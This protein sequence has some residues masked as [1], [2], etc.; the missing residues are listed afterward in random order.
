MNLKYLLRKFYYLEVLSF[1]LFSN[2]ILNAQAVKISNI[3]QSETGLSVSFFTYASEFITD[4]DGKLI[5]DYSAGMEEDSPGKPMLPSRIFFI[6]IPPEAEISFDISN[7]QEKVFQKIDIKVSPEISF[8]DDSTILYKETNVSAKYLENDIYPAKQIEI[9]GYTWVR[10]FYCAVIRI[11]PYQY[12]WKSKSISV[13]DSAEVNINFNNVKPFLQNTKPLGE[14]DNDLKDVIINFQEAQKFRSKNKSLSIQDSTASWIDYSKT[15]YKLGIIKDGIYRITFDNLISYGIS[16]SSVNPKTLKIFRKGDQIPLFVKGED[17]LSFDQDDYIEFWCEKNYGSQYYTNVV[18]TGQDYLNYMDRYSDTSMVWLTFGGDE[19]RRIEILNQA[20]SVTADTIKSHLSK[21]HF[22]QDIRLWYY[23]AEDPRTQLPFWQEHKVFTWLTIGNSGSQ[24]INFIAND[25]VPNTDVK[26]T[27]R[28]ISNAGNTTVNTHKHG[29]SLNSTTFQDSIIFNYRQTVNFTSTFSSNQLLNGSNAYR[30]FGLP[31]SATFH[32]SL[33]DWVDIEYYRENKT[34]NDSL[35]IVIPDTVNSDLRNIRFTNLQVDDSLIVLYKVSG[36]QKKITVYNYSNGELVFSDSVK[37]GD[38]YIIIK[39]DYIVSPIFKYSKDFVNLRDPSRGA[40]Y[41]IISHKSLTNSVQQYQQ[42]VSD[43][44]NVR[45]ELIYIDDIYDEFGFGQNW[46]ESIKGFLYFT[47]QNWTA[48]APSY[49]NLIGDANYDYKD[50]WNP[51]PSPRKKNLV[52]SYGNPV[53][54]NWYSIWDSTNLN[55]PQM[56]IGRIPANN[57]EEVSSYLEKY[58]IYLNRKFDDWNKRY[59]FYSGG[60]ATKP[61][62]LAQI[63]AANDSLYNTMIKPYPIGGKGIHFYKTITPPTN[64]GPYSP[65]EIRNAVDSSGLF[66]SYIGHSGTRTWDNGITEVEDIKNIFPD[67]YPLISDFGCSTGKFAEPDVDAFGELFVAQSSNGQAIAYLGNSSLGYLSTSLRYPG[68]FYKKILIDSVTTISKAHMLAK[69]EQFSLY[70]FSDVNRVF[71]FCNVLFNDPIIRFAVPEKPNF[72]IN[73]NSVLLTPNQVSDLEDSVLVILNIRNWGNVVQDSLN[74]EITNTFADSVIFTS[75]LKI[76]CPYYSEQIEIYVHTWGLVGEH[77]LSVVLD[78][79]NLI[80]EIYEN[81]NSIIYNFHVSSSSIRPVETENYYTTLQD[82]LVFLNPNLKTQGDPEEFLLSV[83]D[84]PEFNNAIEN[85]YSMGTLFTKLSLNNI[86]LGKRYWYRARLNVPQVDWSASYSFKNINEDF[87]WYIDM[88][89]NDNDLNKRNIEFDSTSQS[90]KI[91]RVINTLKITSAGSNDGKFASMIFNTQEYLPNTFFW[92]IA[93]SEIDSLTLEPS[94]IKYFSWPNSL[95]QNSDSLRNYILSLPQGKLLAMTISDDGVQLVLGSIGS[96]V[97]QAIKTL[98]SLYVDSVLYRQSWCLLGKKGAAI[99]SVPESYKKLFQGAAIIDTSKLVI[100]DEGEITFPI[101]GKSSSWLNV[102]VKDSV[103][104]GAEITMFPLGIRNNN[105]VDTLSVLSFINDSSFIGFIDPSIYSRIKLNAKFTANDLK[106][107]PSIYS[108]GVNYIKPPELAI[109][110]Q[111]VS[112]DKDSVYQGEDIS[113]TFSITNV[114]FF[115]TDSFK[116]NLDLVKPDK[117]IINLMDTL[118]NNLNPSETGLLTYNYK[119]NLN[120][121]YGDMAF[122][123]K[124]DSENS[125]EEIYEDNNNFNSPFY[126]KKDTT[127]TSVSEA[128]VSATFDGLE[129]IDGDYTSAKPD[130]LINFN[131]PL[132]FPIDDTSAIKIYLDNNELSY[133]D[134][135]VNYDTINRIAKYNIKPPLSDGD[136]NL[137]VF[138]KDVN[139]VISSYPGYEKYFIV[140]SEFALLNLYNF[141]NPFS[142]KTFFTFILPIIPEEF[143]IDIYT[144]AGRKIKEIKKTPGELIVG[145]NKIEWNGTDEDGDEIANGTYLYKVIIR[146]SEESFQLTQKLSKVK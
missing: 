15:H 85:T 32:R 79:A 23:D 42:F 35:F 43:N 87:N 142:D 55:I 112:L 94:N 105:Q 12:Q 138:G 45:T 48:P 90:W 29:S 122:A 46:A 104:S 62:E 88:D 67:R 86:N 16:P 40:D 109:N 3:T 145:F 68:L 143:K 36:N 25:F 106:E 115:K 52:P 146:S 136:H 41:I 76:P 83:S 2:F 97:R 92:G 80:D 98:G 131:Y 132:W 134:F 81:D 13:I 28:L 103:P 58:S 121:G 24:R 7:K 107:S 27:A 66:I 117:Q 69:L 31:T 110:Y 144:I 70:G 65:Q 111:V 120:D 108:L 60:D 18:Q 8:A 9:L 73:Q 34:Q 137:K 140:S 72:I 14:F 75:N 19:G 44:Y 130:I 51:A 20:P 118:I 1:I 102:V 96:P 50:I 71:N 95:A 54:D 61:N 78:A 59:T 124:V 89:H 127:V 57:N 17:D 63:K 47:N 139:G 99:G 37:G 22:E 64:F 116:V 77:K 6:A 128:S 39:P 114:G 119:S 129:I 113:I 93:T 26:T 123:I 125:V 101:A 84:D 56:Y 10:D 135:N 4:S 100:F 91:S 126:V 74:I 133:S 33:I 53:S 5:F 30:V 21:K 82:T 38:K 49:L 11:N 141:P